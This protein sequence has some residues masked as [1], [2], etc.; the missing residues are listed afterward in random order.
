MKRGHA[1]LISLVIG[2]A[3]LFGL[4]AA[5]RTSQ[6]AHPALQS[7]IS[8]AE[9]ARQ[10]RSLSLQEAKLKRIL[11][12]KPTAAGAAAAAPAQRT[13]YVRPKPHIVTVHPAHGEEREAESRD[14]EGGG[15][16]D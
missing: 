13:I 14:R 3:A 11:A 6:V 4:A 2:A 8:P 12:R 7:T 1:L 15:L 9:I 10:N 5:V 16:D